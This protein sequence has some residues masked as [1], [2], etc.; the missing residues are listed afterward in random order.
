[1]D[2][3]E[4]YLRKWLLITLAKQ[5]HLLIAGVKGIQAVSSS[6]ANSREDL[7]FC[8]LSLTPLCG[9]ASLRRYFRWYVG[10]QSFIAV[11]TPL[12]SSNFLGFSTLCHHWKN[13]HIPVPTLI[14][15]DSEEG[16]MLLED[17]GD[18][19]LLSFIASSASNS[20][21]IDQFYRSAIDHLI[22]IQQT[23][24]PENYVLPVY[25]M[26]MLQREMG[27]FDE[28]FL[29]RLLNV[30]LNETEEL[31]LQGAYNVLADNALAQPVAVV[32]RDYHSRNLMVTAEKKLAIIDFQDAVFGP[33][34]YDLVSLLKDCYVSWP[35]PQR[36]DWLAYYLAQSS[37]NGVME[38]A[39]A[40]S[41]QRWFDLMGAQRHLKAI[42]IFARLQIRDGKSGYLADI[43]RTL[44]Y[45]LELTDYPELI[46][47]LTWLRETVLPAMEANVYFPKGPVS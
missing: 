14:A 32:H 41:F 2:L 36:Q 16:F 7:S 15:E 44:N 28:W 21:E 37:R 1:M 5:E 33:V 23:V 40:E 24:A 29:G 27:L 46:P 22:T 25:D 3:R 10:D 34:S 11:D 19:T 38:P 13:A 30:D 6:S 35:K 9:D 43:P 45:L 17:L 20:A 8:E 4:T 18:E 39:N 26:P 42:G 31:M 47:L 12:D